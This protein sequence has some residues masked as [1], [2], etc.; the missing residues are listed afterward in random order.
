MATIQPLNHFVT[1]LYSADQTQTSAEV[2][3]E[4]ITS[5]TRKST[6]FSILEKICYVALAAIMA[7]AFAM[8]YNVIALS[9]IAAVFV[10]LS[11]P[12]FI[13]APSEFA[14]LSHQYSR[15]A[16]TE[17]R[18]NL[19]LREIENWS[20]DQMNE[21]FRG[22]ALQAGQVNQ[23]ALR[24]LSPQE[25]MRALLPLMARYIAMRDE[26]DEIRQNH[27]EDT[28][29]LEAGFVRREA[30]DGRPIPTAEKQ[31]LRFENECHHWT[32]LELR[33]IPIAINA[34]TVLQIIQNP[35]R[36]D[37]DIT[38]LS[39]T[40]PGLGHSEPK[41]YP[42]RMFAKNHTPMGIGR[43]NGEIVPLTD[44]H[45]F[46]RDVERVANREMRDA[47]FVFNDQ[48][49]APITHQQIVD[50]NIEPHLLRPMLYS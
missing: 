12:V 2:L 47:Y 1:D 10:F 9:S 4:S 36:E 8:S 41:N 34:A 5:L 39:L 45:Q 13:V 35:L 25:P 17:T 49:R 29:R 44:E 50:A 32:N 38:P 15:L 40:V 3:Q 18:I 48:T 23:E 16:E 22:T 27:R 20:L 6:L 24:R 11:A 14:K 19:K 21:F 28:A 33:A 42:E 46:N 43:L 7:T 30:S 26:V 31:K 37:L